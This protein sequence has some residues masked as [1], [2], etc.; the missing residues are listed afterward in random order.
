MDGMMSRTIVIVALLLAPAI[1]ASA[2]STRPTSRPGGEIVPPPRRDVPGKRTT[3]KCGELFVPDFFAPAEDGTDVVLWFLGA[4]WCAQQ[5]FY[6]AHKNAVLM[7]SNAATLKKGFAADADLQDVLD[8]IEANLGGRKIHRICLAS[9]SG[10][11]T[12]VRDIL[13]LGKFSELIGDVVLADSLYAPK[14][15]G[16]KDQLEPAAME[17]FLNYA[18]R[19]ADGQGVFLFSHLFP[20]EEQY[21]GNTTTLAASYLIDHLGVPRQSA[22]GTNSRGAR[23]LY[24]ADRKQFHVLGY[25]GMTNQ[26][27]FEH[28]YSAADLLRQ[29]S[30]KDAR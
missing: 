22:S 30:L 28:F 21:R 5:V 17:P 29:T 10:G 12:A 18:R 27:H 4:S 6:D 20:P 13:R 2:Q 15:A 19:A 14:V 25:A 1:A 8:E 16:S 3:L 23:L 7:S 11:Y 24:R 26:D 9:F